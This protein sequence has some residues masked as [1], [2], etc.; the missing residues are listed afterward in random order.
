MFNNIDSFP[1]NFGIGCINDTATSCTL[2]GA[3]SWLTQIEWGSGYETVG[4]FLVREYIESAP[5][6]LKVCHLPPDNPENYHT[7]TISEDALNAHLAHGDLAG[8]CFMNA[9]ALC[10]DG[11]PCTVDGMDTE[12][13]TCRV[14]KPTVNC[15]DGNLC[16]TDSCDP[17]SGCQSVPVACDD[18]D[19]CTVDACSEFDGQCTG[20]PI[21]CGPLGVCL[22]ETGQCDG[23]CAGITC[24][25]IGQCYEAGECV[26]PGECVTGV[27]VANGTAC[28]DGDDRTIEDSCF[29]GRCEG[30]CS[31]QTG[32]PCYVLGGGCRAQFCIP[33]EKF[34]GS[35]W[36]P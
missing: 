7:I 27:P 26:W 36:C 32:Y 22:P 9:E 11:N 35:C 2:G 18:G 13:E 30:I 8:G 33:G 23:P 17:A 34:P 25:P 16:T 5:T 1:D 19:A 4:S 28:D 15:D 3:S 29:Q 24:D 20:T 21:D 10:D 31:G 12:T 6:N 14:D